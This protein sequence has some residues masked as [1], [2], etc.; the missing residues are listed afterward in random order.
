MLWLIQ[1]NLRKY[2]NA[3]QNQKWFQRSHVASGEIK[4][5]FPVKDNLQ[6]FA[7]NI[8]KYQRS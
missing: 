7:G 5:I 6:T 2:S 3:A 1:M 4:F 8:F